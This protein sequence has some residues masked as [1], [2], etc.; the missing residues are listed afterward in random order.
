MLNYNKSEIE[1]WEEAI[2]LGNGNIGGLL[3]GS[4]KEIRLNLDS[5][6]LWDTRAVKKFNLENYTFDELLRLYR[7]GEQ[8]HGELE[9]RFL[10]PEGVFPTKIPCCALI[11][12]PDGCDECEFYFS[13][14]DAVGGV[15]LSCGGKIECFLSAVDFIGYARYPKGVKLDLLPPDYDSIEKLDVGPDSNSLGLLGYP[16]G[17][18]E[19]GQY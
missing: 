7:G 10:R 2:P 15:K 13:L 19:R 11:F 5:S 18:V 14:D 12:T 9:E 8:M 4:K 3:F 6:S 1:H 17:E 16:K